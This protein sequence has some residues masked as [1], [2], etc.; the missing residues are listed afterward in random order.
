MN[1]ANFAQTVTY[2]SITNTHTHTNTLTTSTEMI[3]V[4]KDLLLPCHPMLLVTQVVAMV[5]YKITYDQCSDITMLSDQ[6]YSRHI[7]THSI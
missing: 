5:I 1:L 4:L 7:N 6:A 3:G 2:C